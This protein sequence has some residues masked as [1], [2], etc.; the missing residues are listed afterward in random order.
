MDANRPTLI[1]VAQRFGLVGGR[2]GR[3]SGAPVGWDFHGG[4][5]DTRCRGA[6]AHDQSDELGMIGVG[7]FFCLREGRLG[8][9]AEGEF[10][11]FR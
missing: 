3:P 2:N 7:R 1:L 6:S 4:I 5:G 11:A 10:W 9:D 8:E